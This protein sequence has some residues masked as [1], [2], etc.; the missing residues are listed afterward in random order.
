MPQDKHTCMKCQQ[1]VA[2]VKFT[3]FQN[4]VAE[5]HHLCPQCA[6]VSSPYQKKAFP[7]LDEILSGILGVAAAEAAG[8]VAP[9]EP[10][11]STCG[12]PFSSYR[13]T[14]I[15]GCSDCYESFEKLLVNELRRFHGSVRHVGRVPHGEVTETQTFRKADDLKSR[16][17]EA[18]RAED[19]GMAAKLRDQLRA[20]TE[21]SDEVEPAVPP[22][23]PN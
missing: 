16:L 17:A 8:R 13:D 9:A 7:Q 5:E 18:I 20:L 22:A 23:T 21:S 6:A 15:L 12:L 1:N 2:S 19:F 10:T 4:G 3:R 11:C 14:L